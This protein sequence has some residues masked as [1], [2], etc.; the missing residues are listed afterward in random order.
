MAQDEENNA[1]LYESQYQEDP[2]LIEPRISY[3]RAMAG[4]EI[5]IPVPTT[6][7]S[8]SDGLQKV[9]M[10][11]VKWVKLKFPSGLSDLR[12]NTD[13]W[14]LSMLS[15]NS[16]TM[17]ATVL[18]VGDDIPERTTQAIQQQV[19]KAL[20]RTD[21]NWMH[22]TNKDLGTYNLP[23]NPE[24]Q[25]AIFQKAVST[26]QTILNIIDKNLSPGSQLN[27]IA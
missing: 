4:K 2:G 16:S 6:F 14:L 7:V 15:E 10:Q 5:S 20:G 18:H 1:S 11:N 13:T 23:D 21:V 24:K 12:V 26:L 8:P 9:S 19:N 27:A 22:I 25:V 17:D 3:D